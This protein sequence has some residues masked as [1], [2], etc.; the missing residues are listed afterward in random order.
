MIWKD[1]KQEKNGEK[2]KE[3]SA[4]GAAALDEDR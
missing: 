1:T 3:K 4:K 2:L